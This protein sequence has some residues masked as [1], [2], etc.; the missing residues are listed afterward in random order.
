VTKFAAPV[1]AQPPQA[2]FG[3]NGIVSGFPS[4]VVSVTG[5]GAYDLR[6]NFVNA[7]GGF[8]CIKPV[9]QGPLSNS[10]NLDDPG[11]CLTGQGVRWDTARLDR[12]RGAFA[13][14]K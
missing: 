7:A 9:N 1:V 10:V 14:R 4:G 5:G 11:P 13:E 2:G 6:T 12:A 3:F 8:S